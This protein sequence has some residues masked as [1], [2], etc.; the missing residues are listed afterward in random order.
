MES[1][2]RP[3][4]PTNSEP[5]TADNLLLFDSENKSVEGE[6]LRYPNRQNRAD[7]ERSCKANTNKNT[8]ETE[9]SAIFRPYARRNRSKIN[10]DPARS[11]STDIVQNRGGLATSVS[12][13]RGSVDGKGCIAE[14]ASQ[15]DRTSVSCPIFANSNGTITPKNVVPSNPLNTKVDGGPVVQ[16]STA[17]SKTSLLKDEADI[18]IRK[19]SAY[20]P[21]EE[22]GLAGEKAQLV[23]TSTEIDSPEAATIAGQDNSS[24]QLNGLRDSTGEKESLKDRGAAGTK[25]LESESSHA[26]SLEVDVD[27][28][29][30]LYRV[31]KLDSDEISMHKASRVEGLL[32]QTVG[33]MTKTKIEDE[34]GRSPTIISE[35][36]PVREMQ[37]NSVKIENQSYRSID[38]LQNEEKC[39]DTEKKLQDE[40]VVPENERKITSVLDD[41]SSSSLHPGNPQASVDASSCMV[42]D[43][44]LSG[45]DIEALKHQ[46]SSDGG[47]KALDTV[48]EDSILEEA[49]MIQVFFSTWLDDLKLSGFQISYIPF[50]FF[51]CDFIH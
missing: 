14:A 1:S 51:M 37:M 47:S 20:L 6:S 9:D 27:T 39:C 44:V 35:C 13:R 49:R 26:N 11:S 8:K 36:S 22:T 19:S 45:T 46:P 32:N 50:H 30:D 10:R 48:K 41:N 24:A 25:G 12:I 23:L 38:E 2:G 17:G 42:G 31:D 34:T 43:N 40:L 5:N 21:S 33:E 18:T 16:E 4:V 29:R 15:K 7:S 28:E 3:G